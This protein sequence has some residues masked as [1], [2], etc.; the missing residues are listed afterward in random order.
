MKTNL[1][2]LK[3]YPIG[4]IYISTNSISPA[5]LFGGSWEELKDH[6]IL[7]TDSSATLGAY[8]GSNTMSVEQ[9]PKHN[10][11]LGMFIY[12]GG[13]TAVGKARYGFGYSK[14]GGT[15]AVNDALNESATSEISYGNRATGGGQPFYPYHMSVKM[16]R[17]TA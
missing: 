3:A 7:M 9:M 2:M 1:S 12:N 4:S 16:W 8:S 17:R 11:D 6:A 14:V 15:L 10:H 5:F 13:N